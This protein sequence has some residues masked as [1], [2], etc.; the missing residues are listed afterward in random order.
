MSYAEPRE[1]RNKSV[2]NHDILPEFNIPTEEELKQHHSV[3]HEGPEEAA[4]V[5]IQKFDQILKR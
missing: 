1:T 4:P 3:D 5:Q 2:L